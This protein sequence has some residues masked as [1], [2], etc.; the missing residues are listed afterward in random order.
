[1]RA[2]TI[3]RL[4]L[5]IYRDITDLQLIELLEALGSSLQ[6]HATSPTESSQTA[7]AEA[8]VRVLNALENSRFNSTPPTDAKLLKE[9][10]VH[11]LLGSSLAR[12]IDAVFA[13]NAVT[14]LIASEEFKQ[15]VKE[16]N[17][18]YEQADAIT[19]AFSY[20]NTPPD[21]L[22]PGEFEIKVEIPCAA[23]DSE[24]DRFGREVVKINQIIGVFT[25]IVTGSRESIKVRAISSSDLSIFLESAPAV[26]ALVATSLERL[27]ALYEKV[28]GI[29][30]L[31]REMRSRD[32]PAAV[33]DPLKQHIDEQVKKGV[34][35]IA[36][37]IEKEAFAR[38]ED[39]RKQELKTELRNSLQQIAY[40]LDRGFGFDV[41]GGNVSPEDDTDVE[42]DA[43]LIERQR[44]ISIAFNR[45]EEARPKLR[46]FEGESEAILG[47]PEPGAE[48]E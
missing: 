29:V 15:L 7:V 47:L 27:A 28:L 37:Q 36:K 17:H 45:V 16:V 44:A 14:P 3:Y 46:Q 5:D 42:P 12:N 2:E 40:R 38:V 34:D 39:G 10:R 11:P 25:E 31:H 8:R 43:S 6:A 48:A 35:A 21:M 32:I 41:R 22:E 24:L 19:D 18:L 1:M 20:F 13:G 4:T 9:M 30:K 33:L 23:I 26:A